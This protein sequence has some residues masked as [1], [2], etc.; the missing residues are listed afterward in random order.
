MLATFPL[1]HAIARD[2]GEWQFS[3]SPTAETLA[4]LAGQR[5]IDFATAAAYQFVRTKP[6]NAEFIQRVEAMEEHGLEGSFEASGRPPFR[7]GIVPG[8]FF[9]EYPA[10]GGDGRTLL[11]EFERLGIHAEVI[12]LPSFR[13]LAE[14]AE[15]ICQ[16]LRRNRDQR[17]VLVSLSK[18][19]GETKLALAQEPELFENVSAWVTLSGILEG[20]P[21]V[22]WLYSQRLRYVA[23]RGLFWWHRYPIAGLEDLRHGAATLLAAPLQLP[24][25]LRA[26]HVVGFPFSDSFSTPWGK[27][28]HARIARLG[29]NDG[30]GILLADA[31]A[32]PGLM[33]PVW[34]ADHYLRPGWDIHRLVVRLIRY[35]EQE[36]A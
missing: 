2:G 34:G 14:G 28:G 17:V 9:R 3:S 20:T 12:P 18:G 10:A 25:R 33:Y 23:V 32:R 21:L 27:R 7:I 11:A 15:R 8:A 35:F 22:N 5:G 29:P 16:W 4:E 26:V 31:I 13:R 1:D 6:E 30:G 19:G 36:S 24:P